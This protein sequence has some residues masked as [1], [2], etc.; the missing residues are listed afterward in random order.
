M[1][2]VDAL[3]G[4]VTSPVR[5]LHR[6][7]REGVAV[8][9]P[10]ALLLV[11]TTFVALKPLVRLALL[12]DT[13]GFVIV[14]RIRDVYVDALRVDVML[15]AVTA[16]V[17]ALLARLLAPGRMLPT[18]AAAAAIW[19][20][21][22]LTLMKA[23]GG[24][25]LATGMDA[26]W[27]PH[28]AVDSWAVVVQ[29]QVDWGR[30]ALK[31]VT[32]YAIPLA[33]AVALVT[34]FRGNAYIFSEPPL[35]RGRAGL[36]LVVGAVCTL[37][38]TAAWS[39]SQAFERL[40]PVLVGDALPDAS[41]RVLDESGV[42]TRRVSL[43]R[44]RGQV[45]LLDFWASWCTP[46]R[47]SFPELSAL[48]RELQGQGLVVLG[49][50]REPFDVSAASKAWAELKPGFESVVDERGFGD[51]IGVSTL[52]TSYLID[53]QGTVRAIH[54]GISALDELKAEVRALVAEG[55]TNP[56]P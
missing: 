33:L 48:A 6:M 18:R 4:L 50:N 54:L 20:L 24:V 28:H 9:P 49:V 53:R 26:W 35:R 27:L 51:R 39:T 52:P 2:T 38:V 14:R 46:C 1:R 32:A 25:L 42:G 8:W 21:V 43:S 45:L 16:A 19:L 22:P 37:A 11:V 5:T 36:A 13:G 23:L 10:M 7:T 3:G 56:R 55:S 30:F 34:R 47:K 41:M 12:F 17:L 44:F 15:L 29:R 40:R 31:C